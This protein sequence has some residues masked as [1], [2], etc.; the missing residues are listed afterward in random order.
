MGLSL[1][2]FA[3]DYD[4]SQHWVTLSWLKSVWE[5]SSKLG[6]DIQLAHLP[7]QPPRE[8]NTWIMAEFIRM[9]YDTQSLCKLNRV[10]LY[11][12]VI[13]LS[14]VM[15]ASG[16]AIK[17]KY[18]DKRPYNEQWSSLIFPKE[19]PSDSDFRL[20]KAALPQIRALGGRLHIGQHLRQGHKIRPWKY[21]IK[22]L[23][24]FYL[25]ENGVDLYKPALG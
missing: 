12:Q 18:L 5:K 21:N 8:R 22:S 16:R 9:N 20:W 10:R 25:K 23:Q 11:Q 2:P 24:L 3:E 7:L 17:S 1:Q 14:D 4:T 15:D 13:F 19:M 6:I